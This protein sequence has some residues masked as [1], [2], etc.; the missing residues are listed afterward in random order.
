MIGSNGQVFDG[1]AAHI[2]DA[3]QLNFTCICIQIQFCIGRVRV[4]AEFNQILVFL[5]TVDS[6]KGKSIN[7]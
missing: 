3:N 1:T 5:Y 4:G 7:K 2:G 6:G